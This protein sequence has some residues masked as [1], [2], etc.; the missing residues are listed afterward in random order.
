MKA[1]GLTG[2]LFVGKKPAALTPTEANVSK[3]IEQFLT[4]HRIYNDR[5][6]S[7]KV[8][9]VTKYFE[10]KTGRWKEFRKWVMLAKKGTP[11]RFFI[12]SGKIYFVEVK[13]MG[14]R[15]SRD[16]IDRIKELRMHGCTVFIASS[17]DSF[18][19]QFKEHFSKGN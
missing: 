9:A 4:A 16:Q 12:I 1:K 6:N 2:G 5:M 13:K 3:A 10:K 17:I 11:D 19:A 7:G 18:I 8:E 14:G 15:L